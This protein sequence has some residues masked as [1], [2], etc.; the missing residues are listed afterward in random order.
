METDG[1]SFPFEGIPFICVGAANYQCHQGNDVDKNTK[2]RR[3]QERDEK[4]NHDHT[5]RK[6]RKHFQPSKK[7]GCP[8]KV[9]ISRV[10]KFPGYKVHVMTLI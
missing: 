6:G 3:Q 7:L 9:I 8:S 2:I 1:I 10:M 4:E 5:F